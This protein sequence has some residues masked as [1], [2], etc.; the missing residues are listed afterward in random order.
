MH[1]KENIS[2]VGVHNI[3]HYNNVMYTWTVFKLEGNEKK[4]SNHREF[5]VDS[6]HKKNTYG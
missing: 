2:N 4:N 6:K 5:R 1:I 3:L